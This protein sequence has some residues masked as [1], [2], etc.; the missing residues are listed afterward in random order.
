MIF[1]NEDNDVAFSISSH[2]DEIESLIQ[3]VLEQFVLEYASTNNQEMIEI[4]HNCY[5]LLG[6]GNANTFQK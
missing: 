3:N 5:N 2:F 1:R 6:E 4:C